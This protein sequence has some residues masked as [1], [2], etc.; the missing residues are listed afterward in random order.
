MLKVKLSC[1]G[2]ACHSGYPHL[3]ESAID[4]MIETLHTLRHTTWPANKELG[5]TTMNIGLMT[6]GQ[7]AN[8]LAE[9]IRAG[10]GA[11]A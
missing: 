6:G 4:P 8:A 3:G 7:A 1:T 10:R 5:E 11:Q 2:V 9:V